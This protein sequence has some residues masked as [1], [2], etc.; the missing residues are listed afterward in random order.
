LTKEIAFIDKET[1]KALLIESMGISSE[2]EKEQ[3][4]IAKENVYF[5]KLINKYGSI[6]SSLLYLLLELY[7]PILFFFND[8]P[9][10]SLPGFLVF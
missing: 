6:N 1:S 5:K 10:S 4:G 8:K 2:Y 7:I 3:V 9:F